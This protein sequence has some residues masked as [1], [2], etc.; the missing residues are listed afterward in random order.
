MYLSDVSRGRTA[1]PCAQ[2]LWIADGGFYDQC[3]HDTKS[4]SSD[5]AGHVRSCPEIKEQTNGTFQEQPEVDLS[6]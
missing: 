3:V 5:I 2:E 1:A 6:R 4:T